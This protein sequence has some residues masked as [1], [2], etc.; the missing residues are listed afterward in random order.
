M[1]EGNT[2]HEKYI[3]RAACLSAGVSAA[4]ARMRTRSS[5]RRRAG[6]TDVE[7]ERLR[8]REKGVKTAPLQ[9]AAETGR[10]LR[11]RKRALRGVFPIGRRPLKRIPAQLRHKSIEDACGIARRKRGVFPEPKKPL[12]LLGET[13]LGKERPNL[14]IKLPAIRL[15]AGER[16][17]LNLAMP[18]NSASAS[19]PGLSDRRRRTRAQPPKVLRGSQTRRSNGLRRSP[20]FKNARA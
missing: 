5:R 20:L 2:W 1:T 6:K 12:T 13:A 19:R 3:R 18:G 10:L 9:S 14:A 15:A 11:S 17:R 8:A 7:H 16:R 4:G